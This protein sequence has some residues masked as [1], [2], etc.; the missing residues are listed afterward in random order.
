MFRKSLLV[1]LIN[2]HVPFGGHKSSGIGC[3]WGI[4]GLKT[5]CNVQSLYL[6]KRVYKD[7]MVNR[8]TAICLAITSRRLRGWEMVAY[9]AE[10]LLAE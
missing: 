3:E 4:E 7:L 2:P 10:L 6:Q 9:C 1:V 5:F 8:N